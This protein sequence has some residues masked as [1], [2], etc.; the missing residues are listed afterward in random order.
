MAK[1]AAQDEPAYNPIDQALV[2]AATGPVA[3]EAPPAPQALRTSQPPRA[4]VPAHPEPSFTGPAAQAVAEPS[5]PT[6]PPAASNVVHMP[7]SHMAQPIPGEGRS[8]VYTADPNE[9]FQDRRIPLSPAEDAELERLITAFASEMGAKVKG[10]HVGRALFGMFM[11][12]YDHVLDR[13]R[14]APRMKR[15]GNGD[16]IG[17]MKFEEHVRETIEAGLR[18]YLTRGRGQQR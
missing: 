7:A 1:R 10:T 15:P 17:L 4:R 18:D 13:G 5:Q 9:R 6:Q 14:R 12:A 3:T 16:P 11:D 2:N 8:R